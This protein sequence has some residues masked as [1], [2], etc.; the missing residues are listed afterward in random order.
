[1]QVQN[2]VQAGGLLAVGAAIGGIATQASAAAVG[3]AATSAESTGAITTR[4][5][6]V[7]LGNDVGGGYRKVVAAPG[8]NWT[9]RTEL[10]PSHSLP[11]SPTRRPLI[12]FAQ[13]T[14]LH[15]IDD[16]SPMRTE[17]LDKYA[18]YG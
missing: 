10:L 1:M 9:L 4:D 12:A 11:G 13:M 5:A 14:D 18:D 8:E 17:Y 7:A 6:T 16:Q 15:I 2:N 3:A